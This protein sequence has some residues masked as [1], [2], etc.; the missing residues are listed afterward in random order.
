MKFCNTIT[1]YFN[2]FESCKCYLPVPPSVDK[3]CYALDI[4]LNC[5][6]GSL[7]VNQILLVEL[8]EN[9]DYILIPTSHFYL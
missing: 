7:F 6:L 9:M 1:F 2:F 8:L 5:R 4:T 3:T